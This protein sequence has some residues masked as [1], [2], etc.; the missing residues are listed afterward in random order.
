MGP[1]WGLYGAIL[2]LSWGHLGETARTLGIIF[3]LLEELGEF[4][5]V[6]IH[7]TQLHDFFALPVPMQGQVYN[8]PLGGKKC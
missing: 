2:G 6:K 1:S 4:R 3:H 7:L 8:L 5:H